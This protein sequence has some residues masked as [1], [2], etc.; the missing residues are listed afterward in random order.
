MEYL[1]SELS[2][3]IPIRYEIRNKK[4]YIRIKFPLLETRNSKAIVKAESGPEL[5]IA[6][7]NRT[8]DKIIIK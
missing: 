7:Y 4:K 5:F 1:F 2:S 6:K 3:K 8:E